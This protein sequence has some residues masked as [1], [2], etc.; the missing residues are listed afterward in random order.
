MA[1]GPCTAAAGDTAAWVRIDEAVFQCGG[2]RW[3]DGIERLGL[4]RGG[5][6]KLHRVFTKQQS[7]R[8]EIHARLLKGFVFTSIRGI[9]HAKFTRA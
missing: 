9:G 6:C 8:L 7:P 4:V 2:D 5:Y 3:L 1:G